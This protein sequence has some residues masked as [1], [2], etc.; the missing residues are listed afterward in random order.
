[1]F[2]VVFYLNG[3]FYEWLF[4]LEHRAIKAAKLISNRYEVP[5]N[6]ISYGGNNGS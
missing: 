6:V 1:M 2:S 4:D 5:C 3:N